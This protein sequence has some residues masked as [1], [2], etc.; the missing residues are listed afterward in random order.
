M[1]TVDEHR[2]DTNTLRR[3]IMCYKVVCET[4]AFCMAVTQRTA[5]QPVNLANG[6]S[7][8]RRYPGACSLFDSS[9]SARVLQHSGHRCLSVPVA[10]A[11][12]RI[13]STDSSCD[14]PQIRAQ[15]D[16]TRTV[17]VCR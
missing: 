13:Q 9:E 7:C 15:S 10:D 11:E 5:R 1:I 6:H 4:L 8:F 12:R 16:L 17:T 3:P 14:R 2:R